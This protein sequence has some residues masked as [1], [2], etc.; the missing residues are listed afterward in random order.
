MDSFSGLHEE[1]RIQG[2]EDSHVLEAGTRVPV[3]W[4]RSVGSMGHD[5]GDCKRC[6]F[7]PKGRCK[8]GESCT[9]CHLEH[10][11]QVRH[12]R[13]QQRKDG[14][15][16][17]EEGTL[18]TVEDNDTMFTNYHHDFLR[19]CD[20]SFWNKL[21][22]RFTKSDVQD[23]E[24]TSVSESSFCDDDFVDGASGVVDV[25]CK[26]IAE[27]DTTADDGLGTC[28]VLTDSDAVNTSSSTDE[29]DGFRDG[30]VA[31]PKGCSV[32]R[33]P[34]KGVFSRE[35]RGLQNSSTSWIAQQRMRRETDESQETSAVEV[36]RKAKGIL[37][38]LTQERFELLFAQIVALPLQTSEQLGAV[39]AEIF[40]KATTQ[41]VFVD[42]YTELCTR[43]DAHFSL[44]NVDC[45]GK[46]FRK[47]LVAECQACFERNLATP[48]D[49]A[50]F[51]NLSYEE[52]YEEE[53]KYKTRTL[54]NM[55][56]IGGLMLRKLL[57]SK[58]FFFI[59]NELLE[60]A[61]DMALECL[62]ELLKIVG[63]TFD[64]SKQSIYTAPLREV[65]NALK[66]IESSGKTSKCIKC[67]LCDLLDAR[68]SGWNR[69]C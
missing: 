54:G 30:D 63:P 57:A 43:L 6:A 50:K 37:N 46:M 38:K 15:V 34:V 31:G 8:N 61:D 56:F 24:A 51:A 7:F 4:T 13:R 2:N 27:G 66:K 18:P 65:F 20:A 60:I 9:H 58:I 52:R 68:A 55:R 62:V 53:V 23:V 17:V 47:S 69:I 40:E 35:F 28:A 26:D 36:A 10:P 67:K 64:S 1:Q 12:R 29:S 3:A 44:G 32:P 39:V 16:I 48:F 5:N 11:K 14:N 42:I 59:V 45:G 33:K 49:F 22:L 41:H 25:K 21:H 19:C